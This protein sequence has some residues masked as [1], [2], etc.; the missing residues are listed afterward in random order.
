MTT[1][2]LAKPAPVAVVSVQKD[3]GKRGRPAKTWLQPFIPVPHPVDDGQSRSFPQGQ[4]ARWCGRSRQTV[5]RWAEAG[6][7][8]D[9]AALRLCQLYGYGLPPIPP[10]AWNTPSARRWLACRLVYDPTRRHLRTGHGQWLLTLP[11]GRPVNV[12]QIG[13]L[14]TTL[15]A[16]S[17]LDARY[18]AMAARLAAAEAEA[19]HWRDLVACQ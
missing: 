7:I 1:I 19:A 6:A 14:C 3:P 4:I 17:A 5:S 13:S 15:P 10:E 2:P 8:P 12:E 9:A 16:Y 11:E 18:Q